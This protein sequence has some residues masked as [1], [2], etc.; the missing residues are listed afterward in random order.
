MLIEEVK[1]LES[2]SAGTLAISGPAF[3]YRAP[4]VQ[5]SD[6][7]KLRISGEKNRMHG[8]SDVVVDISVRE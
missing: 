3:V 4:A 7:F 5:S 8:T 1:V 6:R 2:P